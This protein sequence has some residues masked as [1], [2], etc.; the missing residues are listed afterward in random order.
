VHDR[1]V[2]T[3]SRIDGIACRWSRPFG[4]KARDNPI[5]S[6]TTSAANTTTTVTAMATAAATPF[7]HVEREARAAD[8]AGSPDG[9]HS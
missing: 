6:E 8:V 9:I 4:L 1:D 7:T 5:A 2:G 3:S